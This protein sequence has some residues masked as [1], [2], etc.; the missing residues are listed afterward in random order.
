M[1][2]AISF[3]FKNMWFLK[4]ILL[5]LFTR[6]FSFHVI[7]FCPLEKVL[8]NFRLFREAFRVVHLYYLLASKDMNSKHL[9]TY[10]F[11]ESLNAYLGFQK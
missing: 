6:G 9:K 3:V 2:P 10:K 11:V 5:G 4:R 8:S 1:L 7:V